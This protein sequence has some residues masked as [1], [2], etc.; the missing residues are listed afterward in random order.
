MPFYRGGFDAVG[1]TSAD[2]PDFL[3]YNATI[4][5]NQQYDEN[6]GIPLLDPQVRFN[7]TRDKALLANAAD[8]HFSITRFTMNGA[9][10]DLPL[11]C[12]VVE[13]TPISYSTQKSTPWNY[14]TTYAPGDLVSYVGV[15]YQCVVASTNIAPPTTPY[16]NV[17]VTLPSY[18]QWTVGTVYSVGQSVIFTDGLVYECAT[19]NTASSG[20]AP[21]E[22]DN[23]TYWTY[24][25]PSGSIYNSD[26]G[27]VDTVYSFTLSYQ[28][29]W[30]VSDGTGSVNISVTSPQ[31]YMFWFPQIQNT[32][33]APPPQPGPIYNQNL[34]SRWWWATD[35]S[36]VISQINTTLISAWIQTYNK[37]VTAW[38]AATVDALPYADFTAWCNNVGVPPQ[39]TWDGAGTNRTITLWADSSC[40][41]QRLATFTDFAT[42]G[43]PSVNPYCRIF[44][45]SNMYG[46]LSGF[47][48]LY[49]NTSTIPV[50][51]FTQNVAGTPTWA[52]GSLTNVAGGTYELLFTTDFYQNVTDYRLS[53]YSGTPPLGFVPAG[54]AVYPGGAT[55]NYQKIYWSISQDFNCVDTLWTPIAGLV[56][57]SQ[58]IPVTK[59][60]QS[61]PITFGISDL[62]NSSAVAQSAFQPIITDLE[63]DLTNRGPD[64]YR[65]F[66]RYEPTAEY[67]LA[68]IAGSG[69]LRNIDIQLWWR[70]RLNGNLYPVNMFNLSSVSLKL[71]F[72]K[73]GAASKYNHV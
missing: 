26:N 46:L 66:I 36:Y 60:A 65:G 69:E 42:A 5:N 55:I 27:S 63:I 50:P 7:E 29:K 16:W 54:S 8:Y 20:N 13:L 1:G 59:E 39:F 10:L 52:A 6:G 70:N 41:G 72:R 48:S 51:Q 34:N 32:I 68:D 67:R 45:N 35:Y 9:N 37:F 12:P 38:G 57:T 2:S 18:P 43:T 17:I 23:N 49:W 25:E 4:I 15:N 30:N 14:T 40:F 44:A 64:A 62:G 19:G 31:V 33:V 53:P 61:E 58:L 11:F 3:W 56:F 24:V 21:V 47:S 22:K 28:Q 73:K 71:L